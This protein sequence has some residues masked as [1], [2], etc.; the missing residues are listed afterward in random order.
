V[1]QQRGF[2]TRA[3]HGARFHGP[4]KG[5]PIVFPLFQ[6]ASFAFASAEEQAEVGGGRE[7]GFAYSRVNNPTTDAF[8]RVLADL[9]GGAAALSFA[10]GIAAI[11]AA[12]VAVVGA[13]EHIVATQQVY[14]G[15][16]NLLSRTLPRFGITHTF[17]DATDPA[18]IA[19]AMRP[20]TKLVWAETFCNPG[21]AVPDLRAL[22]AVAH[23]HGALLAVDNT[24]ATPYLAR[25]LAE[26]ADIV[27]HSATKYI[28][29]H[30]DLLAG[31]LVS[32]A[33][34]VRRALVICVDAG[35]CAAPLEAWLALRGLKTLALRMER[36]C[37]SALALA[38]LLAEHP[39]VARVHY[40]GLAS[41]PQHELAAARYGGCGGVLSFEV[42]DGKAGAYRVIDKLRLALRA[43]S[44]GDA[45]TLVC[46]PATVSHR[47]LTRVDREA[48]GIPDG[49]VRVSVGLED[50]A[51]ILEDF[52]QALE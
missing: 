20:Q 52:R 29:G 40:P 39:G 46:H 11:H 28:G 26:G 51:D 42:H 15:T 25:P 21:M 2:A 38:H 12:M 49:M 22:A 9:E 18:A 14:G 3:I 50:V 19:R 47:R 36:H 33:E 24:F 8:H 6:T 17:A 5:Q 4:G 41:H 30:G 32:S 13:G 31:A 34:L 7:A 10:S 1:E 37:A 35:G 48:A 27:V 44:L 16:Y 23:T 45:D 43:S